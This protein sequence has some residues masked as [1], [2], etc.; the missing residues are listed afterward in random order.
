VREEKV[1][2][3]CGNEKLIKGLRARARSAR[4]ENVPQ[5][6]REKNLIKDNL[7]DYNILRP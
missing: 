5:S 1:I 2:K 3:V 7:E 6:G 4:K